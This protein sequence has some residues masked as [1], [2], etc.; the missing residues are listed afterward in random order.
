[1]AE[2]RPTFDDATAYERFMGRWSRSVGGSFLEWLAP[3]RG[4]RWLDVGCGTGA[5]TELVL[6]TCSPAA[7]TAV[8]PAP[9]LIDHAR[10]Q[11]IAQQADFRVAD[12]QSLPFPDDSFDVVA[13][14]LVI[15]FIPDR[16]QAIREMRRVARPGG[17]VAGYV[18]D[19]A[20]KGEP[21]APMRDSLDRIGVTLVL[22]VGTE[23]STPQALRSLFEQAGFKDVATRAIEARTTYSD[24]DDFWKA[25]TP[26]FHP[27]GKTINSLP[28]SERQRLSET[29]RSVVP[30]GPDGSITYS[31]RA[32]AI[33]AR[34]P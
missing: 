1:V 17:M 18:W 9:A 11:P 24:F 29:M 31:A 10:K 19:F 25:Q 15:N 22:T 7:L 26:D 6:S 4:A 13:S 8:D 2:G 5:F 21:Y 33:K 20:A 30:T 34:V 27:V 28:E 14:A 16:P 3:P 12:C 32:N 23:D